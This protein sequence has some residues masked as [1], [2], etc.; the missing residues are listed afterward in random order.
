MQQFLNTTIACI[1]ALR[2]V[3]YLKVLNYLFTRVSVVTYKLGPACAHVR[4]LLMRF[5]R[6][7]PL[8]FS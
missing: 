8:Y 7:G 2:K 5:P 4:T 6:I 1:P 3:Q